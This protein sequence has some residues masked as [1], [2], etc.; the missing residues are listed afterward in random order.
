MFIKLTDYHG[1]SV[2]LDPRKLLKLRPALANLGDPD[3]CTL[4]DW[5]IGGIFALGNVQMIAGVFAPYVRLAGLH[6]PSGGQIYL[7]AG[8]IDAVLVD[9]AYAGAC[10]AVVAEAFSNPRVPTRNRIPLLESVDVAT[11]ALDR[12]KADFCPGQS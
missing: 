8:A 9:H 7:N 1:N 6:D 4:V 10:V 11:A 3:G 12:A 2:S 5:G